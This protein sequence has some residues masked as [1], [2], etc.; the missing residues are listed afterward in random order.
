MEES[1]P[2]VVDET[3]SPYVRQ[4]K[5][6]TEAFLMTFDPRLLRHWARTFK[7]GAGGI[8]L[9]E[10][11]TEELVLRL[12]NWANNLDED[13]DRQ[14]WAISPLA[15]WSLER[16]GLI[17]KIR[18]KAAAKPDSDYGLAWKIF[19]TLQEESVTDVAFPVGPDMFDILWENFL[20]LVAAQVPNAGKSMA[21]SWRKQSGGRPEFDS[22]S[23]DGNIKPSLLQTVVVN[24]AVADNQAEGGVATS[25]L[26]GGTVQVST[27]ASTA[28]RRSTRLSNINSSQPTQSSTSSGPKKKQVP[29]KQKQEMDE[30]EEDDED[31]EDEEDEESAEKMVRVLKAKLRQQAAEVNQLQKE[32]AKRKLKS[33]V[34]HRD[35][36]HDQLL[37]DLM[38]Q[39]QALREE[40]RVKSTTTSAAEGIFPAISVTK[41]LRRLIEPKAASQ[42]SHA[43]VTLL[44]ITEKLCAILYKLA[45]APSSEHMTEAL[46]ELFQLCNTLQIETMRRTLILAFGGQFG[47]AEGELKRLDP[48]P[49]LNVVTLN[50][51]TLND[52]KSAELA[53]Y[54]WDSVYEIA[55]ARLYNV[56]PDPLSG[57]NKLSSVKERRSRLNSTPQVQSSRWS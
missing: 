23:E 57:R 55:H 13:D 52:P 49:R 1:S 10:S 35:R 47:R 45:T 33:Q 9:T 14:E 7:C 28:P 31:V 41:R 4:V 56:T 53:L 37:P 22:A 6:I 46:T 2:R 12:W 21:D 36:N 32:A 39:V 19:Q 24:V 20:L 25:Q 8:R 17:Y 29:R 27:N 11:T 44:E 51:V 50:V 42:T 5:N 18:A 26:T 34:P 40:L 54:M 43:A 15:V 38:E 16:I 30:E 3:R 48:E